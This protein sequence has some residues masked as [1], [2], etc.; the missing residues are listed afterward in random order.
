MFIICSS[1]TCMYDHNVE[2]DPGKLLVFS[3]LPM[4]EPWDTVKKYFWANECSL[5]KISDVLLGFRYECQNILI[6]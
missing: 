1:L 4:D 5:E 3:T 2:K 6:V